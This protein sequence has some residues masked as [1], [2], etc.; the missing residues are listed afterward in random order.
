MTTCKNCR[1]WE[2]GSG[3]YGVCRKI[4]DATD[5]RNRDPAVIN[6][7]ASDDTGLGADLLT[8]PDFGCTNFEPTEGAKNDDN[9]DN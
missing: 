9:R 7:W 6:A 4:S 2:P 5:W 3:V 8:Q 1:H